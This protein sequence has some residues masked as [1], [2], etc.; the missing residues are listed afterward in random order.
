MSLGLTGETW[1]LQCIKMPFLAVSFTADPRI[2]K[3][4]FTLPFLANIFINGHLFSFSISTLIS[5]PLGAPSSMTLVPE[6]VI[7][8]DPRGSHDWGLPLAGA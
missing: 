1:G 2:T 3:G 8:R 7:Q 5:F 6:E 4:T